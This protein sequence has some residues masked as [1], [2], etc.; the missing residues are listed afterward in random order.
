MKISKDSTA[1]GLATIKTTQREF[2]CFILLL[3]SQVAVISSTPGQFVQSPSNLKQ[4][5]NLMQ[6][7]F[8]LDPA[9]RV[10]W[11]TIR[12]RWILQLACCR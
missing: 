11:D 6:V 4:Q 8:P 12:M 9:Y 10:Q 1:A 2:F 5:C 3:I 7:I